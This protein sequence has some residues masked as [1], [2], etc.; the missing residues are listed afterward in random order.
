MTD[1]FSPLEKPKKDDFIPLEKPKKDDRV[2]RTMYTPKEV[3]KMIKD[4]FELEQD[5]YTMSRAEKLLLWDSYN[6]LIWWFK[7]DK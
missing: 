5:M 7:D 3:V 1:D 2:I 6:R 4:H